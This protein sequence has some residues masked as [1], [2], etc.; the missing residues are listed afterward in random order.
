MLIESYVVGFS[1]VKRCLASLRQSD[2][3]IVSEN[4]FILKEKNRHLPQ[5]LLSAS[6][7][8]NHPEALIIINKNHA[9][10][11][12]MDSDAFAFRKPTNDV[13][14]LEGVT[15]HLCFAGSDLIDD[16]VVLSKA[17]KL[18]GIPVRI[19]TIE[20]LLQAKQNQK[21]RFEEHQE[22]L[23]KSVSVYRKDM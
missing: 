12:I 1:E 4:I 2:F 6:T 15:L 10:D 19:A 13:P 11:L 5:D 9:K 16:L 8:D 7:P 3:V 14:N 17:G 23:K 21:K 22:I 20:S 18:D